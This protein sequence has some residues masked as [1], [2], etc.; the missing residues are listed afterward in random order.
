MGFFITGNQF[1]V[2][3]LSNPRFFQFLRA[4]FLCIHNH[5]DQ[6]HTNV[7]GIPLTHIVDY[8]AKAHREDPL[9][10]EEI[11]AICQGYCQLVNR[12]PNTST[13]QGWAIAQLIERGKY[14]PGF[15]WGIQAIVDGK[16]NEP[17]Q[18]GI[19]CSPFPV[20]LSAGPVEAGGWHLSRPP[21][22]EDIVTMH[23]KNMQI[24]QALGLDKFTN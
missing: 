23:Y 22:V 14:R 9:L 6:I 13:P 10:P 5:L 19:F 1:R 24:R 3:H 2:D 17:L 4:I 16:P 12:P 11:D 21:D 8:V 15:G 18:I 7:F 20:N